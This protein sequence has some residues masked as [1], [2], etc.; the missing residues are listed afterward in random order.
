MSLERR[1]VHG[2]TQR[3]RQQRDGENR[4]EIGH[5]FPN[6]R[7]ARDLQPNP[8]RDPIT[9]ERR[10]TTQREIDERRIPF[11]PTNNERSSR[12]RNEIN[13]VAIIV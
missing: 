11:R 12:Y 6:P 10:S 4:T 2:P 7:R 8:I 1:L 3:D 5:G 9:H 13:S